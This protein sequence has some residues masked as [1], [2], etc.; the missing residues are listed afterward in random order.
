MAEKRSRTKKFVSRL[1]ESADIITAVSVIGAAAVAAGTWIVHNITA[2]TN[3]RLDD[4]VVQLN[5]LEQDSARSQLLA[6]MSSY[7]DNDSEIM[8]IAYHYFRELDGDWYM[9]E[10][11]MEWAN[12]HDIDISDII[13][14]K[15][16]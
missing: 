15:G 1:K 12:E 10:L 2:E 5:G 8:K 9:T 16:K 11:F 4:I 14:V 6:L 7:P 3:S 13:K